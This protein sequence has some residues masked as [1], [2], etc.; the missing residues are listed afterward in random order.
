MLFVSHH[1]QR[2]F[3]QLA[4]EVQQRTAAECILGCTG[5]A[6][7]GGP[8]E[9][10]DAPALSLWLAH[11]PGATIQPMHLQYEPTPEGPALVGWP[12]TLP[13]QESDDSSLIVLAEPFTFPADLLLQRLNEDRPGV[14]VVGGMASGGQ[15]PGQNRLWLNGRALT[16]GAVVAWLTGAHRVQAIVS[17]GCRPIGRKYVVTKAERNVIF[18]LGGRAALLELKDLF[19]SLTPREQ[20]LARA[21]LHVGRVID[22]YKDHL[23]PGDFLIRNVMGIDPQHGAVAIGDYVRPGQSVQFHV[24]DRQTA[25]EEL[26]EMLASA[27]RQGSRPAAALLFTC[28]G[29]GTRMF[30][31]P[32]HD[33]RTVHDLAGPLPLA[34]LFAAGEI[35]PV[36]GKN[37]VHGF[38]ASVALFRGGA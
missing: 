23:G 28:N 12:D 32:D 26:R 3:S 34:G 16:G 22:E 20:Q 35:G 36:G 14:S 25:D 27:L 5:E 37:F 4:E 33:A 18:E 2:A 31:Q 7:I 15:G 6:I 38:T 8:R 10:E 24:R 13:P 11:L 9:I 17:Q 29:R 30:D 21:G 1:H 19:E